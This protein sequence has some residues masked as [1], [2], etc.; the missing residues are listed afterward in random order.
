MSQHRVLIS[1]A[2]CVLAIILMTGS[3]SSAAG[4]MTISPTNPRQL[5]NS[6]LYPLCSEVSLI[7][8]GFRGLSSTRS[9]VHLLQLMLSWRI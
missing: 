5:S 6:A 7:S 2:S 9:V 8:W 4:K 3:L 1:T